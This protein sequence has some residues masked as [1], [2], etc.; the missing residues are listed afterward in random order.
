MLSIST[1]SAGVHAADGVEDLA[2]DVGDGGQHALAAEAGLVAVAQFDRLVRAGG[3]PG[4]TAARPMAPDSSRT[5]TSTVGL[6]RLSRISRAMMSAMSD[7]AR[8]LRVWRRS[9]LSPA[10]RGRVGRACVRDARPPPTLP[11]V[12]GE[13]VCAGVFVPSG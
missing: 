6:P 12:A 1:C 13:G 5:S 4:G 2:L 8:L 11:R 7:M 3:G 10:R 9:S